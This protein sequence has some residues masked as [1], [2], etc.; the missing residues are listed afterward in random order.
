MILFQP[1]YEELAIGLKNEQFNFGKK[2]KFSII[3]NGNQ[4][5]RTI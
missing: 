1:T 5:K 3:R 2:R 4:K